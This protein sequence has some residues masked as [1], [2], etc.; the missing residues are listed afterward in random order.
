MTFGPSDTCS[1]RVRRIVLHFIHHFLAPA[2]VVRYM[3]HTRVYAVKVEV[4]EDCQS[5]LYFDPRMAA[6]SDPTKSTEHPEDPA[7]IRHIYRAL[8]ESDWSKGHGHD[9]RDCPQ[10]EYRTRV[11]LLQRLRNWQPLR[12]RFILLRNRSSELYELITSTSALTTQGQD[13]LL[14]DPDQPFPPRGRKRD[15]GIPTRS[16]RFSE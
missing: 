15:Q 5:G 14:I 6:H 1:Q 16:R 13:Q 4:G 10:L 7:R 9:L 11:R 12:H 8:V 2:K 3:R